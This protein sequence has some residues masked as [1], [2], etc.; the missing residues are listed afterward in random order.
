VFHQ[1]DESVYLAKR[2]PVEFLETSGG[3]A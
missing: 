2:I 1:A 3:K